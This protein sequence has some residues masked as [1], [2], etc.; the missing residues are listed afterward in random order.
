ML[1][2]VQTAKYN[3]DRAVFAANEFVQDLSHATE[4]EYGRGHVRHV[5][6]TEDPAPRLSNP[7]SVIPANTRVGLDLSLGQGKPYVGLKLVVPFG[8]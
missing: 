8:N 6:S 2:S 5:S 4:F 7:L 1:Q 3:L